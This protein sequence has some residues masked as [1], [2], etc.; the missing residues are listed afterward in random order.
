MTAC[1]AIGLTVKNAAGF[2]EIKWPNDIYLNNKKIA[3]IL[4]QVSGETEKSDY[5]ILGIGIN[6]NESSED[7]PDNLKE[8]A[9]SIK[10]VTGKYISRKQFLSDFLLLFEEMYL[11]FK[12]SGKAAKAADVCR[13]NSCTTGRKLL[14]NM[15]GEKISA[16]VI[17][18]GDNGELIAELENG[19]VIKIS[20]DDVFT[21]L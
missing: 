19:E 21:I 4:T 10:E 1:A 3:G 9:S 20:A 18:L 5:V 17:S 7:F 12:A 11:E 8:K 13:Q 16:K 2:V 6:V 14:I 15:N